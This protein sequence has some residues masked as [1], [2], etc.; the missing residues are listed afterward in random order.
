MPINYTRTSDEEAA[1]VGKVLKRVVAGGF[2]IFIFIMI[3]FA[4]PFGQVD[5]GHRG[6]KTRFGAV[7]GEVLGEG[8]YMRTPFVEDVIEVDIRTQITQTKADAA[9]RDLQTVS[10][11]IALNF[12][13]EAD[14]VDD[15]YQK[16]GKDYA[17][18][19]IAPAVQEGF[20]SVSAKFTADE[21]ITRREEVSQAVTA[22]LRE[23]LQSRGIVAEQFSIVNFSFS[24]AFDN[25]V[26]AKVTAE[27]SALAARNK[28]EQTKFEAQAEIEKARGR[29]EA[30]RIESE[31]LQ[32]RPELLE[33][34][35]IEKWSGQLPQY[36]GGNGQLPFNIPVGG[37]R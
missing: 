10:A 21:L 31:A 20:K 36:Y 13:P 18:T 7:T 30:I 3:L 17:A 16:L 19:V 12:R 23:R 25:A 15:I 1:M 35:A 32:N 26:E 24:E 2:A 9:S 4:W 11:D 34:R 5:A 27:Q 29:A 6:I 37:N 22:Y 8:F 33:L 28:L 14:Q